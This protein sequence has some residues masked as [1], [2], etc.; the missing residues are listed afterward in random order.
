[1]LCRPRQVHA[2]RVIERAAAVQW[3]FSVLNVQRGATLIH[4]LALGYLVLYMTWLRTRVR[5]AAGLA[6]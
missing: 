4:L 3:L 5:S 6:Q 1:M 2:A